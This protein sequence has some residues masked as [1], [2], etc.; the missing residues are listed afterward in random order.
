LLNRFLVLFRSHDTQRNGRAQLTYKNGNLYTFANLFM[1]AWNYG[2]VRVMSSYYFS[3]TDQG[4]PS[5]GVSGGSHCQDGK[6]WVCEHR[7]TAI[8]NMVGWRNTAGTSD[9]A[10]WQN[11]QTTNQIAFSRGGKA[12]IAF[13]RGS[14]SSWSASLKTGLPAG[15]YCNVIVS[16]NTASCP[17]IAVDSNGYASV[18]VPTVSA[19]A[20]HVNKKK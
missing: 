10:N 20:I 13:N 18:T 4:P 19:V 12:F 15:N 16:D 2:E 3:N 6:N 17:P 8:A 5:V 1:L 7:W 9:I 11:G 14:S